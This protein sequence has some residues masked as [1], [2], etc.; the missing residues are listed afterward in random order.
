MLFCCQRHCYLPD[1]PSRC[2]LRQLHVEEQVVSLPVSDLCIEIEVFITH[3]QLVHSCG[4]RNDFS[5]Q[6]FIMRTIWVRQDSQYY[7]SRRLC[8]DCSVD[9]RLYCY[10]VWYVYCE[11]GSLSKAI[12]L[13]CFR[14]R[15]VFHRVLHQSIERCEFASW[16]LL[17]FSADQTDISHFKEV[18]FNFIPLKSEHDEYTDFNVKCF[19][20]YCNRFKIWGINRFLYNLNFRK[21]FWVWRRRLI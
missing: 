5:Q 17:F 14:L 13:V 16:I 19:I 15:H 11:L 4:P 18:T 20:A 2:S 1:R 7:I 21:S 3:H 9:H 12:A 6:N 8:T 10:T